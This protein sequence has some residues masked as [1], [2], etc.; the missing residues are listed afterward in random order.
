MVK[1]KKIFVAFKIWDEMSGYKIDQTKI[2]TPHQKMFEKLTDDEAVSVWMCSEIDVSTLVDDNV[3][4]L[5][6]ALPVLKK[7]GETNEFKPCFTY[8]VKI[9]LSN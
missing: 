8:S 5:E 7:V 1:D 9:K 4:E 3:Q 2:K 6:V